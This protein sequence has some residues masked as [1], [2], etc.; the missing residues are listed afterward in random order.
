MLL[1]D[2]EL[3]FDD[4][5]LAGKTVADVLAYPARFEGETLADPL[6]GVEY[7]RCKARFMR[8]VDGAVWINSFAHGR[9]VYEL[10]LDFSSAKAALE[11]AGKD[12]V[13]DLLV[14]L[15]LSA[16][17][18]VRRDRGSTQLRLRQDRHY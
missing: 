14:R 8:R 9:T 10:K 2:V 11:K 7:G 18:G 17:L 15:V 1:R 6:E 5:E 12:E 4:P 3:P 16:D 13:A